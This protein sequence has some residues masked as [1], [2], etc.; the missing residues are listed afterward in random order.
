MYNFL[1]CLR[2]KRK[3]NFHRISVKYEERNYLLFF[4]FN[5]EDSLLLQT[6][7]VNNLR[8]VAT[9]IQRVDEK[10]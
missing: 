10:G 9:A 6:K 7:N 5:Y 1:F 8:L 2:R 3:R 4:L